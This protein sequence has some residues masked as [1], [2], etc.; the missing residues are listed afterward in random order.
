MYYDRVDNQGF[1]CSRRHATVSRSEKAHSVAADQV[2]SGL[3]TDLR[4][5]TALHALELVATVL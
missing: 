1:L 3:T 5:K 4:G 2:D